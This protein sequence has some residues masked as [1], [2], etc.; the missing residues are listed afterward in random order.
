MEYNSF[1]NLVRIG[2]GHSAILS[3]KP[4]DW[5]AIEAL[6]AKQGLSAIIIDGIE[7]L[8]ENQRPP[9]R[10]GYFIS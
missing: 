10:T 6:A 1:L 5:N 4:A 7:C 9:K 8:P 2:I 3:S